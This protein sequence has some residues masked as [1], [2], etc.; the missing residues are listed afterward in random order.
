MVVSHEEGNKQEGEG[1]TA[2]YKSPEKGIG[3][4]ALYRAERELGTEKR[5]RK[6]NNKTV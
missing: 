3:K 5:W 6:K 1:E 2:R 4:G